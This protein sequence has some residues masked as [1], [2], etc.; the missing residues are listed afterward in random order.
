MNSTVPVYMKEKRDGITMRF[1]SQKGG[2]GEIGRRYG[3]NWIEPWYG[4]LLSDN[5]QIQRNPG[6][7]KNGQSWAKSRFPKTNKGSESENQKDR[8]RDSME[9]VLT[10]G[11]DCLTLVEKSFYGNFRKDE[12]WTCI[13]NRDTEELIWSDSISILKKESNIHWSNHSLHN[14]IDLL[15]NWLIGRE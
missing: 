13:H 3:L 5:F 7:N 6:I 1:S 2:Y 8:C 12:G 15:K 14:L 4:N 9:A 10:N 11:V